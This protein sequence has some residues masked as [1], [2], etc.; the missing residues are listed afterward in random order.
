VCHD[1]GLTAET[2]T[3]INLICRLRAFHPTKSLL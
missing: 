2:G 1:S 3:E